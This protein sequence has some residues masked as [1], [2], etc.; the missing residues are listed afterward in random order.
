MRNPAAHLTEA[1]ER[2]TAQLRRRKPPYRRKSRARPV[3]ESGG[4]ARGR[5]RPSPPGLVGARVGA[6]RGDA[7]KGTASIHSSARRAAVSMV[8]AVD[9]QALGAGCMG[10][11]SGRGSP[12]LARHAARGGGVCAALCR[13]LLGVACLCCVWV[14]KRL[15]WRGVGWVPCSSVLDKAEGWEDG[16]VCGLSKRL[17]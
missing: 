1:P 11:T 12:R 4:R 6:R 15:R 2:T 17:D 14:S 8:L 9:T 13:V 7:G 16:C 5:P 10:G 3:N